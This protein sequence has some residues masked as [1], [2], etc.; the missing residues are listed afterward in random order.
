MLSVEYVECRIC[1]VSNML[2]FEYVG[3]RICWVSN[4]LGFVPQPNLHESFFLF[5]EGI[6]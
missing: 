4:M 2:G 1:W 3:F 5:G 6:V